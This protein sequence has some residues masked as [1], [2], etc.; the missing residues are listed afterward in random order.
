MSFTVASLIIFEILAL[1]IFFNAIRGYRRGLERSLISLGTT[2]FS[3]FAAAFTAPL[4]SKLLMDVG[5]DILDSTGATDA[6]EEIASGASA[7][8]DILLKMIIA[9]IIYLPL[10]WIWLGIANLIFFT[11]R[12]IAVKHTKR[13]YAEVYSETSTSSEI[14]HRGY[15]A[16]VGGVAGLLSALFILTPI[17]GAALSVKPI[18]AISESL[19]KNDDI[20]D[21]ETVKELVSLSDDLGLNLVSSVGGKLFFDIATTARI[22]GR[23]T[24][25]NK[26]IA[27]IS[28]VDMDDFYSLLESF[29][30]ISR[31]KIDKANDLLEDVDKSVLLKYIMVTTINEAAKA[32]LSGEPYMGAQKPNFGTNAAVVS[33]VNDLLYILTSTNFDTVNDDINTL[34]EIS[35]L[36]AESKDVFNSSD[37]QTLI[38][39]LID[40]GLADKVRDVMEKNPHMSTALNTLDTLIMGV[41]AYELTDPTKYSQYDYKKVCQDFAGILNDTSHLSGSVRNSAVASTVKERLEEYGTHV[42]E[43]LEE[44]IADELISGFE[45]TTG[46]ITT[47]DIQTFF[48]NYMKSG[49]YGDLGNLNP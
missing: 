43:G 28:E 36:F 34:L 5:Y 49:E 41:V 45:N 15:G 6:I 40:K 18:I 1:F 46:D 11:I 48:D 10:F 13:S 29:E 12:R 3:G 39:E 20:D 31:E 44:K 23:R 42:P 14:H 32:W 26:E 30:T 22:E 35:L 47:A 16:A 19:T 8:I 9:V 27:A 4:I 24:N 33:F 2:V 38:H 17:A 7:V 25:L 21:D 37:Y